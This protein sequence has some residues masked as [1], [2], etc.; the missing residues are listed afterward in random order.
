M[1]VLSYL[2]PL[3]LVPLLVEKDDHEV[4]WHAKH[5]LVL[6]AAWIVAFVFLGI[7]GSIPV[8][9]CLAWLVMVF[10][11]FV[12]LILHV[13][14]IVKGLNGERLTVPGI[15]NLVDRFCAEDGRGRQADDRRLG[16]G[17]LRR[18]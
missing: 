11:L 9:G 13:V 6:L 5:G 4:Q 10:L 1:I 8:I 7:V 14:C 18:G 12:V 2:G 17:W 16:R 15:S 3:A